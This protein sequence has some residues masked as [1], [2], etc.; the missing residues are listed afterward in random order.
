MRS[1]IDI[2]D[3]LLK[4]TMEITGARTKR[5][6]IHVALRELVQSKLRERLIKSI[7][8]DRVNLTLKELD[9]LRGLG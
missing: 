8:T 5:E 2:D 6:A 4:K 9:E 3:D 7:G 1:T